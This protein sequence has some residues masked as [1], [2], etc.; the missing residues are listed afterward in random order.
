L[1]SVAHHSDP[2][3]DRRRDAT[4]SI[5]GFRVLRFMYHQV[6]NARPEVERAVLAAMARGDHLA[7]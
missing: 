7:A 3:V 4:L 5:L 6:V 2:M 1:D